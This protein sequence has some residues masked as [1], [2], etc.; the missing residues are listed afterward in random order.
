[1]KCIVRPFYVLWILTLGLWAA[2]AS[3]AIDPFQAALGTQQAGQFEAAIRQWQTA[4]ADA[5]SQG[6]A[7][8]S[9]HWNLGLC[10]IQLQLPACAAFHW[11][12]SLQQST[13]WDHIDTVSRSLTQLQESIGL[14]SATTQSPLFYFSSRFGAN[15]AACLWLLAFWFFVAG[16]AKI[17]A[18]GPWFLMSFVVIALGLGAKWSGEHFADYATLGLADEETEVFATAESPT[19]VAQLP[20]GTVVR[21][22][23]QPAP[24]A[25]R[26]EILEPIP[27]WIPSSAIGVPS[28]EPLRRETA[29][30][31]RGGSPEA[32]RIVAR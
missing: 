7:A 2:D 26:I 25:T 12:K 19:P 31:H 22:P 23:H 16:I 28:H 9:A 14:T 13:S 27:G 1:M 30:G 5:E 8:S 29:S 11:L 18:R 4:I 15:W 32:A 21:L 10:C 17:G 20:A 24:S 3:L 6:A